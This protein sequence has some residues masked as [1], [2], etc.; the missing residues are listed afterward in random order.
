MV[1]VT[2][3]PEIQISNRQE[4]ELMAMQSTGSK[5]LTPARVVSIDNETRKVVLSGMFEEDFVPDGTT[6]YRFTVQ[7]PGL[8]NPRS[9]QKTTSIMLETL[10]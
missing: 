6:A 2:F 3:P 10:D 7:V 4:I 1:R 9:L 8:L 5:E